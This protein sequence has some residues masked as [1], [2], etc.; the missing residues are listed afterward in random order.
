MNSKEFRA[1]PELLRNA[2]PVSPIAQMPLIQRETL[3]NIESM[4][5]IHDVRPNDNRANLTQFLVHFFKN[6][7]RFAYLYERPY[8]KAGITK[9]KQLA[10]YT[11]V[12]TPDFS[13]YPDMP[14][15]VGK[16]QIF[17]SRWCGAH[18]QA[19]GLCVFPTVTWADK[20]SFS[21]CFD[22]IPTHSVVVVSTLGC[23]GFKAE[24]L[25]GYERMLEVLLPQTIICYGKPFDEMRESNIIC[26]PYAAFRKGESA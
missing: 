9:L 3:P 4:L 22:G 6:D 21:Y 14:E 13:L 15:P 17:K 23:N 19:E 1:S 10:Q 11:A 5:S 2:Y 16:K 18:W 8:G 24:F 12:C 25:A 7:N 20:P 26:F